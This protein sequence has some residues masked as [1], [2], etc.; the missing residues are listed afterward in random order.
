MVILAIDSQLFCTQALE[1]AVMRRAN[2]ILRGEAS[3]G[4]RSGA[5][6]GAHLPLLPLHY[7]EFQIPLISTDADREKYIDIY[8]YIVRYAYIY[9]NC[10]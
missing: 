8:I 5:C 4:L 2:M 9:L 6:T 3:P 10:I 7:I 1:E